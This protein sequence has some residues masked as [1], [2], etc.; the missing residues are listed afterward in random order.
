MTGHPGSTVDERL[1][2]LE[3]ITETAPDAIITIDAGGCIRSFSPAAERIFGYEAAEVLGRDIS[4]L[5]PEPYASAHAGYIA[6]YLAT[7]EKRVIG[8]G[9]QVRGRHKSGR[10]IDVE[11]AVGEYRG[12]D[13]RI[14]TG[15]IRDVSDRVAAVRETVRLRRALDQVARS[16]TMGE[17]AAALAH[18][19]NQPLAAISNFASAARRSVEADPADAAAAAHALDRIAQQA[20]RAGEILRRMRRLVDRGTVAMAPEDLNSIMADALRASQFR[21]THE[22]IRLVLE[23][24]DG[25]PRVLADRIQIQQVVINLLTNAAEALT[26]T[27]DPEIHLGTSHDETAAEIV[28]LAGNGP[29]GEV[30]VT[31]SD[32]GPGFPDGLVDRMFEP[33]ATT[34]PG[35]MGVGLAICRSIVL[36]HGGRIW[37]EPRPGGGATV[38]FTL[39][40]TGRP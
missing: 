3:L 9:R 6:R 22:G 40:A 8:I 12:A 21:E 36:A 4:C 33:L 38:R 1:S 5:M 2:L 26:S 13:E 34:K 29:D 32:N 7:G 25:L 18:E 37:L 39:R 17:M 19:I 20:Q 30:V 14:F 28:V 23:L 10:V 31:V 27:A 15:F 35:G 24:G 11:L 16:Q